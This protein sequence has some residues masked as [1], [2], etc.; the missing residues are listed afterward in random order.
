MRTLSIY[1]LIIGLGSFI[2]P[3]MG[4][5][6]KVIQIFGEGNESMLGIIL[7]AIGAILLVLSFLKGKK[8]V[9]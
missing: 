3:M 6:F 4:Y 8:Q 1:L 7:M 9:A 5:Q 2:L